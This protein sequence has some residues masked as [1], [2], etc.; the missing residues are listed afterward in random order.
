MN[1]YTTCATGVILL[2]TLIPLSH[3]GFHRL[4]WTW[5]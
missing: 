2:L 1:P 4:C 5:C 3:V